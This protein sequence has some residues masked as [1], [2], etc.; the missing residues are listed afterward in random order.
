MLSLYHDLDSIADEWRRFEATA[1]GTVFQTFDWLSAWQRNIGAIHNVTPAIVVGRSAAGET[2]LLLPLA[3]LRQG[4]LRTLTFLGS[5]LCDYNGPLLAADFASRIGD[6][7]AALWAE[8]GRM[9]RRDKRFRHDAVV[10]TKLP[11]LVGGQPNPL[12]SLATT[13]HPSGAYVA[14]LGGDWETFY[15]AK[16]SSSWRKRDRW[17]RKR[18][19]DHGPLSLVVAS[20]VEGAAKTLETLLEQKARAFARMGVPNLFARAG[21]AAFFLDVATRPHLRSA[22]HASAVTVGDKTVATNFGLIRGGRFYHILVSYDDGELSRFGPGAVHLQE[23]MRDADK[24]GC[25]LFDFTIGDEA[26]KREWSD[27]TMTLR[28]HRAATTLRGFAVVLPAVTGARV[29][30]FVK[31]TPL[32]WRAV[33]KARAL[34]A[35]LTRRDRKSGAE[36]ESDQP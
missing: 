3:I 23:I 36:S 6:G 14:E 31:Q 11:E 33:V 12:L 13:L 1:D 17:K 16:R 5:D 28:D 30:R 34:A 26:Y 32:L 29:K 2:L 27:V 4:P 20:D 15:A 22:V 19:G 35:T 8:I 18:L 25:H 21:H 7:F 24:R 9:L 10:L